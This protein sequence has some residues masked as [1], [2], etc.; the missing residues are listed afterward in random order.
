MPSDRSASRASDPCDLKIAYLILCH[1]D[2]SHVERLARRLTDGPA[3]DRVFVH[4]DAKSPDKT[5][6]ER[7]VRKVPR[8][9][10]LSQSVSVWWG[11]FSAV[12]ATYELLAAAH[13][14]GEFD[15]YVLLQGADYPLKPNAE[16]RTFF[17]GHRTTEF[18]RAANTATAKSKYLQAKGRYILFF[19]RPNFMKKVWNKAC[20]L[21]NLKLRGRT[22]N[23][24]GHEWAIHWGCAQWA[25]TGECV[26]HLLSMRDNQDLRRTFRTVF[27][28]DETFFHTIVYNSDF[29][30]RTSLGREETEEPKRL[31]DVRNLVYFEY[32]SRVRVFDE[33]SE[34]FLKERDELFVRKVNTEQSTGLLDT[35]DRAAGH[36]LAQQ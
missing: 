31:T 12:D 15:R 7:A 1:S 20:R 3:G 24:G 27:P 5:A 6:I 25:L 14:Q 18:I 32:P 26:K 30:T 17:D 23:V 19:D 2:P 9:V 34:G 16:I 35:L 21:L 8:A 13:S 36:K 33:S 11:G 22:V 10:T 4:I 29:K 28:A